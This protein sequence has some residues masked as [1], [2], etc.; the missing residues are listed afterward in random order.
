MLEGD[1]GGED[2]VFDSNFDWYA[3]WRNLYK[4]NSDDIK[5]FEDKY[6]GINN[7]RIA[8]HCYGP[9][10]LFILEGSDE[11]KEDLKKFYIDG[12]GSLDYILDN[13]MCATYDDE[14]RLV[15]IIK[16]MISAG[17]IE[18]LPSFSKEPAKKKKARKMR[19]RKYSSHQWNVILR[20]RIW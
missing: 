13:L 19:V 11:E 10:C 3:F 14:D 7:W 12:E 17:E 8:I 15:K 16:D 4:F 5:T 1:V 9:N 20:N 18:D 2:L 6:K